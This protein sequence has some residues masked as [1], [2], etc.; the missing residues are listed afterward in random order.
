MLEVTETSDD[1]VLP[2]EVGLVQLERWTKGR[3]K[4]SSVTWG[5]L[6]N[7]EKTE[8]WDERN[9]KSFKLTGE[10]TKWSMQVMKSLNSLPV[11]YLK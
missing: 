3:Y 7:T 5:E 8:K 1:L 2:K 10:N 6:Y 4:K 11:D 9:S